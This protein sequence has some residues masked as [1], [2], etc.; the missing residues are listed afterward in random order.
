MVKYEWHS[1]R[2]KYSMERSKMASQNKDCGL[3]TF[4]FY[5]FSFLLKCQ[6]KK[7]KVGRMQSGITPGRKGNKSDTFHLFFFLLLELHKGNETIFR[8]KGESAFSSGLWHQRRI[9][10]IWLIQRNLGTRGK[11]NFFQFSPVNFPEDTSLLKVVLISPGPHSFGIS[12]L[13][14]VTKHQKNSSGHVLLCVGLIITLII[15]PR[16]SRDPKHRELFR[17]LEYYFIDLLFIERVGLDRLLKVHFSFPL[18]A[19]LIN[20]HLGS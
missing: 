13:G 2:R 16:G 17:F 11:I 8:E 4:F 3:I 5:C 20:G 1:T 14:F 12:S 7:C 19:S 10:K 9:K 15:V 18:Y 6:R